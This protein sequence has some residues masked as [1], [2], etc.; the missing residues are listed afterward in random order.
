[1]LVEINVNW[2]NLSRKYKY[3]RGVFKLFILCDPVIIFLEI[4][5]NV[6]KYSQIFMPNDVHCNVIHN[7]KKKKKKVGK[8]TD[9]QP[10]WDGWDEL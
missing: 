3:A 2:N 10:Y 7:S 1:M 4:L 6:P 8:K 5:I 9:V